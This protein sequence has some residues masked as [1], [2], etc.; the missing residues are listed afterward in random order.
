MYNVIPQLLTFV[1]NRQK[2]SSKIAPKLAID[3]IL[4]YFFN[5]YFQYCNF[6]KQNSSSH[7]LVT[8]S[9]NIRIY[10]C[11][12]CCKRWFVTFDGKECVPHSIDQSMF[13]S[14]SPNQGFY[15]LT[16]KG[17]CNINKRGLVKVGLSVGHCE[18]H[19]SNINGD[20]GFQTTT[21]IFIEEV[22][23]QV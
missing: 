19:K 12:K 13:T 23:P 14:S 11:G 22:E 6:Q 15:P 20:T 18:D 21:R 16:L 10:E 3:F 9:T 1:L 8:I 5:F 17:L 4:M 2:C 7:L